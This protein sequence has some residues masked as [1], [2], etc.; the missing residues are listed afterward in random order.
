MHPKAV[1]DVIKEAA[2]RWSEDR[3]SRLAAALAYYAVFALAPSLI[4]IIFVVGQVLGESTVRQEI[5]TQIQNTVGSNGAD[6]VRTM[7]QSKGN[8]GSG[9]LATGI[10][11]VTIILGAVGLFSHLQ[12]S[13]NTVWNVEIK[14][15]SG[16]KVTILT[17]LLSFAAIVGL[18]VLFMLLLVLSTALSLVQGYLGSTLPGSH[19]VWQLANYGLSFVGVTLVVGVIFKV[20]PDAVV[21]WRDLWF[22]AV[23]TGLLL[24]VGNVLIGLYLGH[25]SPAS[26][27]GAAGAFVALL[28]WI[29]YSAQIFLFGAELTEVYADKYGS[30][31]RPAEY[32]VR[33]E[34]VTRERK[35]AE[36]ADSA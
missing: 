9:I 28:L 1:L 27:Y 29:Y 12:S 22:G 3:A 32:A 20:L 15:G 26:S 21:P 5:L 24:S 4:I 30:T 8:L 36:T 11:V 33:V 25:A 16:I 13:L 7:I 10:G 14:K 19:Y 23:V 34:R 17:R 6:L 35:G 18:G 2:S 31:I